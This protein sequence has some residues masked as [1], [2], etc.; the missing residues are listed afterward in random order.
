MKKIFINY[1]CMYF[2][3]VAYLVT[4][5][6]S[7]EEYL[8]IKY[9]FP[10]QLM[11]I[12][13]SILINYYYLKISYLSIEYYIELDNFLITRLK[14]NKYKFLLMRRACFQVVLFTIISVFFDI[15]WYHKIFFIG[16][17]WTI[18][19][20]ILVVLFMIFIKQKIRDNAFIVS[21]FVCI[22]FRFFVYLFLFS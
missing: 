2:I 20:E 8:L 10:N 22:I 6:T 15:F 4:F 9:I 11:Q 7:Y 3:L 21:L 5:K 16:I 19:I 1:I 13:V 17:L 18:F 14:S 12:V